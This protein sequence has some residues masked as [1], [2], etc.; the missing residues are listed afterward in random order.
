MKTRKA[1][2]IGTG[3][4]GA[5]AAYSLAVQGIVD[6]LV[7]IDKNPAKLQAEVLDLNDAAAYFPYNVKAKAGDFEDL[8]D[9]DVI[10]NCVGDISILI[11]THER[12]EEL[13]FNIQAVREYAPKI[14]ASGFDGILINISNPCDVIT[15]ELAELAGLPEGHVLGTGTG[16][17]TSRFLSAIS[18]KTG[19]EHQS[20]TG[21]MLGEHGSH[22]FAP[23]S[24]VT[25]GGVPLEDL[26]G[27]GGSGDTFDFDLDAIEYRGSEGGWLTFNG[28]HCTEYGIATTAA[29]IVR[30]ILHDEKVIL[31][32]SAGLHGQYGE[33]DI[34][35]GVPAL[36]G[37]DGVEAIIELALTK[38]EQ[39]KF[40]ECCSWI[41]RNIETASKLDWF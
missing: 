16:L 37:K 11:G 30:A 20:I 32:V 7:L 17:D 8:K 13:A 29:R 34:F 41:R 18:E 38:E 33:S 28:K 10:V 39:D 21:F 9:C 36:I 19:I 27:L 12:A 3:H 26:H 31:P 25:I 5:H 40:H 15:R 35:A 6:E 24:A 4:V 1:G 14:K 22:Q 23:W 2:I